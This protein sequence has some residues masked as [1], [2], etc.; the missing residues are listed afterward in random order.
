[1]IHASAN[2]RIARQDPQQHCQP[3]RATDAKA[4]HTGNGGRKAY[5]YPL[6]RLRM[7]PVPIKPRPS[8]RMVPGSGTGAA[9]I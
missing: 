2:I 4:R 1:M 3:A 8:K 5:S 9:D 7:I 6:T